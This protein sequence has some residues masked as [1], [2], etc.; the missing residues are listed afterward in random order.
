MRKL[1][2]EN[3]L[4]EEDSIGVEVQLAARLPHHR[5][6]GMWVQ[7]DSDVPAP[8]QHLGEAGVQR[9]GASGITADLSV[10]GLPRARHWPHQHS[11]DTVLHTPHDYPVR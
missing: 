4:H 7:E 1:H 2:V 5:L 10:K 9:G 3:P 8:D 11:T 6:V